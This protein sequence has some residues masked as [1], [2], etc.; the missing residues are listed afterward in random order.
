MAKRTN[1]R[2]PRG[3]RPY[4][5]E[6]RD[7]QIELVKLHRHIIEHGH[8]VLV[9]LEGRDAAGKDG[10]IKRIVEHLSPRDTRVVALGK[11]SDREQTQWYFQRFVPHLPAA[12][13]FVLF[14]RSW[15]NRAGVERVMNFC[16]KQDYRKFLAS[17][18]PFERTLVDAGIQLFK[19]YLD[20]TKDEQKRRLRDR[21]RDPLTRWKTSPIDGRALAH[22]DDYTKARDGMLERTHDVRAP[23]ILVQAD[24]KKS[25]RLNMIRDLV[26]RIEYP[27]RAA[28]LLRPARDFVFPNANASRARLAR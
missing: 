3:K 16:T 11:P 28:H 8:R 2:A 25:A 5:K 15:Y 24:H 20:I 10:A 18:V 23:W 12:G 13:E 1:G 6:L 21:S 14:N 26:Q 17:V 9:I 22:W 19:Y 7:L 4:K 27:G